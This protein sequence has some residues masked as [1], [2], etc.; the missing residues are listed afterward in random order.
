MISSYKKTYNFHKFKMR[1]QPLKN[2]MRPRAE[3]I[4]RIGLSAMLGICSV[5]YAY[6]AGQ[7]SFAGAENK[8]LDFAADKNTGLDKIYVAYDV[9]GL[10]ATY[11]ADSPDNNVI[12][13]RY[14]NL[15]GGYA[16]QLSNIGH[17]GRK[18]T[19]P[20]V[21]GDMGYIVEEG[22]Q[23][24]Y[25]WVVDYSRHPFELHSVTPAETQD[26]DTETLDVDGV[27][28]PIHYFTINGQ[29]KVLSRDVKVSYTSLKWD[30]SSR[31]YLSQDLTQTFESMPQ[32]LTVRPA[33]LCGTVY[34]VEGDRFL[35]KWGLS[36]SAE[37]P[38]VAPHA[39][40]VMTD[41]EQQTDDDIADSNIIKGDSS[42]LGGSAPAEVTF[43]AYVTDGVIHDEWQMADDADF[44]VITHR[45]AD[46]DLTY[47]FLDEG[48]YYLRYVGSNADG[49]CDAYG[50]VYTV[51]IGTSELECPNAFS[52]NG[53]GVNDVW[54]VSYRSLLSFECWIFDRYGKQMCHF[55]DPQAGWDGMSHGKA[56]S[57]GVYYYVIQATGADGKK[58]KKSG[59]IN[60]IRYKGSNNTSGGE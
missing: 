26:C 39:V 47:T 23:R 34:T 32:R 27:G 17:E 5:G 40:Q 35:D 28:E 37:T 54:K 55:T 52:P 11:M 30:N 20:A 58:Y 29:Q 44:N 4:S 15:G 33:S 31:S 7:L 41:A 8:V 14:S 38:W 56:V 43:Y 13:Y 19:L 57:P 24:S 48:V 25:F 21:E 16:E 22:D 60:I 49:S 36:E 18:W 9:R 2:G 6:G 53:D 46:R 1:I 50:D 45:F 10:S 51:T 42:G 3:I 12:W 59:D